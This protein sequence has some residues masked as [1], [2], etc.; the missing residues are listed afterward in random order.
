MTRSA[1]WASA[2]PGRRSARC[3]KQARAT[4]PGLAAAVGDLLERVRKLGEVDLEKDLLPS[5]G[6]EAAIA[7]QP[8]PRGSQVP[9][10]ELIAD[11]VDADRAGEAL[12]RLEGPI[13]QA[14]NPS[15]RRSR[16]PWS[17]SRRSTA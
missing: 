7:L 8:A 15:S 9:F 17:A 11:D 3:S 4:E 5:L 10:L 12:A 16:P 2:T 6:G 14:L 13:T 1:T